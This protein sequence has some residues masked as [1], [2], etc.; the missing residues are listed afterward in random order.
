MF[1]PDD[2]IDNRYRVVREIGSGGYGTVYLADELGRDEVFLGADTPPGALDDDAVVLRRVAIKILPGHRVDAR[3]FRAEVR[4]LCRLDHPNIVTFF[5]HGRDRE[6]YVAMEFVD[7]PTLAE[8]EPEPGPEGFKRALR[9]LVWIAEALAHAHARGVV[10][11]DLKPHNVVIS[12]G[13]VPRVLDFG[14]AWLVQPDT[15]ASRRLGTPGFVAPELLDHGDAPCDHRVDI[16]SLGATMHAVFTGRSPFS[17]RTMLATVRRQLEGDAHIDPAFPAALEPLLRRCLDPDPVRRPRTAAMVAEELRRIALAATA[18]QVVIAPEDDGAR[19]DLCDS[20]VRSVDPFVHPV[21]GDGV[22]LRLA[23]GDAD[24]DAVGAFAYAGRPMSDARRVHD[25]L[26][27]AWAGAEISVL[28]GRRVHDSRG[29]AFLSLDGDATVVLEPAFPIPV[30]AIVESEGVRAAACPTRWLVDEREARPSNRHLFMGALAHDVLEHLVRYAIDASDRAAFSALF[31]RVLDGLRLKALA[32]GLDDDDLDGLRDE[33]AEHFGHLAAWTEPNADTRRGRLAEARRVSGRFGVDGR[34]DVT[35]TD[36]DAVRILELKTGRSEQ[37][38]HL[39]Q[40]RCYALLWSEAAAASG[41]RLEGWVLYSR[42]GRAR[43]L[44]RTERGYDVLAA[45]NDLVAMHRALSDGDTPYRPP[46]YGDDKTLCRDAPCRFR[47]ER[48]QRQSAVVGAR[49]ADGSIRV[50]PLPGDDPV[51]GELREAARRYYHHMVTLIER[52]YRE[53]SRAMGEVHRAATVARRVEERA[54]LID[55]TVLSVD[56]LRGTARLQCAPR[57]VFDPGDAIVLHRGQFDDNLVVFARVQQVEPNAVVVRSDAAAALADAEPDGWVVDRDV[58][59]IGFRDMHRALYT[60]VASNDPRRLETVLLPQRVDG[61]GQ[62]RLLDAQ[63]RPPALDEAIGGGLNPQQREA[64]LTALQ[65]HDAFLVQGPPGTGKTTVIAELVAELVGRG[66]R[67]LLAA[68][69]NTALDTMLA[70]VVR[71]GVVDVLRVGYADQIG[72]EL[73]DALREQ[74]RRPDDHVSDSVARDAPSLVALRDRLHQVAVVAATTHRCVSSPVFEILERDVRQPEVP[75][76]ATPVFDVAII[77]EA[78]QLT[79]PMAL[80]PIVRARR[81]VLVG[82][83]RQLPP[84]IRAADAL[85]AHVA[86]SV[87]AELAAAGVGGLDRSLFERLKPWVPHIMLTLQYRMNDAVQAF[88]GAAFYG[89]RLRPAEGVGARSFP[90]EPTALDGLDAEMRR[91]V[92]PDRPSVWVDCGGEDVGHRNDAEAVEV[93][94][95]AAALL[96]GWQGEGDGRQVVGV[97]APFR[98]QCHAIRAAL[99]DELGERAGD[100]EVDTVER[101]QGREKEAILV[102]LVAREWSDFVMDPRRLNVTLTR[103]R[104]K[105]VVFGDAAV[106]RR[107]LSMWAPAG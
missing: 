1:R 77:D 34:I 45:R 33:L 86:P 95:T 60:F 99:R 63:P 12:D 105:V 79:E 21:R 47:R 56:D 82:D 16:Y 89:A 53:A 38:S 2:I 46:L 84:V 49:G 92:D 15:D 22:R 68:G 83:D 91:R 70:R 43:P 29:R 59:R 67:V 48:C 42:T 51:P 24:D 103:A 31:E 97:V 9:R 25:A 14:L 85:S 3:R 93:A 98:A 20:I 17:D 28:G 90:F 40:L 71:R 81:F 55:A 7:G 26:T 64:V 96:R 37:P 44:D 101:F 35:I 54:A 102:S 80:A 107:M 69:T 78:S 87:D 18:R 62:R 8:A 50:T 61:G 74:G 5:H 19:V 73:E 30:T 52:E 100:V 76:G 94:R 41:R 13:D 27:R 65:D 57:G 36:D 10:H 23:A 6:P 58:P 72:G 75:V 106:G 88:P 104:T 32:A 4:S 39:R 11:R 66:E